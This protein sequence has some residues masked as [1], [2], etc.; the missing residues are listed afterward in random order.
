MVESYRPLEEILKNFD[1]TD[2]V[3]IGMFN[4]LVYLPPYLVEKYLA[5]TAEATRHVNDLAN[6]LFSERDATVIKA[7]FAQAFLTNPNTQETVVKD[8]TEQPL[9]NTVATTVM[10]LRDVMRSKETTTQGS[11]TAR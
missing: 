2:K 3:S 5:P 10:D 11:R 4:N 6:R 8:I 7:L 9:S 1:E